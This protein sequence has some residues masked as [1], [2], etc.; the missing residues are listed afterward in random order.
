MLGCPAPGRPAVGFKKYNAFLN[1]GGRWHE[2]TTN[3][4]FLPV[5]QGCVDSSCDV[6]GPVSSR[7]SGQGF[8]QKQKVEILPRF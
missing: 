4:S 5:P 7:W 6:V 1:P 3:M 2:K 8:R